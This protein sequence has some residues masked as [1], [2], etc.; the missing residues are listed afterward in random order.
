MATV[1]DKTTTTTYTL[2]IN[3][4]EAR[5]LM[6][7]LE[8]VGGCP[9]SSPRRHISAIGFALKSAGVETLGSDVIDYSKGSRGD[10]YLK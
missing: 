4:E 2:T 3:H 8:Q 5:A 6:T 9:E 1:T 10:I 7:V